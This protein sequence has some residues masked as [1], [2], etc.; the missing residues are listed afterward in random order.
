MSLV[1]RIGR[2]R[3]TMRH[4]TS[5]CNACSFLSLLAPIHFSVHMSASHSVIYIYMCN[6]MYTYSPLPK[7][8]HKSHKKC[9][10][11]HRSQ[12]PRSTRLWEFR[13]CVEMLRDCLD[14]FSTH[15]LGP[16]GPVARRSPGL[17]WLG[18]SRCR[19]GGRDIS[20]GRFRLKWS[21]SVVVYHSWLSPSS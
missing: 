6:N 11:S 16:R 18:K 14:S 12:A 15:G 13:L 3:C 21:K 7:Y 5:E 17:G 9:G 1:F 8:P 2:F 4:C 20:D 19:D 10:E